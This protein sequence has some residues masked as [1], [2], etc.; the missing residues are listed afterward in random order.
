MGNPS[1]LQVPFTPETVCSRTRDANVKTVR[2][3][4][5][6]PGPSTWKVVKGKFTPTFCNL[7][8]LLQSMEDGP[9]GRL[10]KHVTSHAAEAIVHVFVRVHTLHQ[11]VTEMIVKGLGM[12]RLVATQVHVQVCERVVKLINNS[13]R[14]H[15]K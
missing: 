1:I 3:R 13:R 14:K 11:Q 5:F 10:G 12:R 7:Y 4:V 15:K 8:L 9:T 6:S 2:Q